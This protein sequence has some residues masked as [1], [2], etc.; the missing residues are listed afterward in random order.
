MCRSF[1]ILVRKRTDIGAIL[2]K[3]G[4]KLNKNWILDDVIELIID[5]IGCHNGITVM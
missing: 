5:F 1:S 2:G 4:G 3:I